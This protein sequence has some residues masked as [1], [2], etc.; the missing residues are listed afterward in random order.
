MKDKRYS[1]QTC[2]QITQKTE[3]IF[4]YLT[5]NDFLNKVFIF[6]YLNSLKTC[7]TE[8]FHSKIISIKC[9]CSS[10]YAEKNVNF[11]LPNYENCQ[12]IKTS[13][14]SLW[15]AP[16]VA[17]LEQQVKVEFQASLQYILMAAHFDQVTHH[18]GFLNL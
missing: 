14:L 16:C 11:C 3:F 15:Q 1:R 10:I 7:S 12:I 17:A 5:M 6:V 13:P 4:T 9:V 2:H 8:T 18:F